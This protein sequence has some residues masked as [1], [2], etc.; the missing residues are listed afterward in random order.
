MRQGEEMGYPMGLSI[1]KDVKEKD[2]DRSRGVRKLKEVDVREISL[3]PFPTWEEA[4]AELG[5]PYVSRAASDEPEEGVVD[6]AEYQA[7][8]DL[9]DEMEKFAHGS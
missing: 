9:L 2:I 1:G 8:M 3:T 6:M 5:S 7:T 4:R